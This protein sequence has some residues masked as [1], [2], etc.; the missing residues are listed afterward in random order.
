MALHD[1]LSPDRRL[2][3]RILLQSWVNDTPQT[4]SISVA[5]PTSDSASLAPKFG[6]STNTGNGATQVVARAVAL[7]AAPYRAGEFPEG[8]E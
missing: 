3:G 8:I 1:I 4:S 6:R 7:A 5:D 2:A